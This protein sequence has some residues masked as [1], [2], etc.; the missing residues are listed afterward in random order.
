MDVIV[1][2]GGSAIEAARR[3]TTTIPIVVAPAARAEVRSRSDGSRTLARPGGNI[4]GLSDESVQLSAEARW[5]PPK[6]AV[7][8]AALIAIVWN[9]NDP[10]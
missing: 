3:A 9:D 8:K 4:T 7:P 10:A 1:A 5:S 6:E 2:Q